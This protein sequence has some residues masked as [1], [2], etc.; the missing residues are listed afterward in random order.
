MADKKEQTPQEKAEADYAAYKASVQQSQDQW[1][2]MQ[3]LPPL[4]R[5][6]AAKEK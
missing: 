5:S 4:D 3:G 1:R 2:Q 6:K